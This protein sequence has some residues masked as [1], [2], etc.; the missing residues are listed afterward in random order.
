MYQRAAFLVA[1]SISI[2]L[3]ASTAALASL[4]DPLLELD[5]NEDGVVTTQELEARAAERWS[6]NDVDRDGKV[7]ANE[8]KAMLAVFRHERFAARDAD[9]SGLLERAELAD[10][11]E[12]VVLRFDIDKNGALSQAELDNGLL[13]LEH[14]PMQGPV[15][16][17]LGDTDD[18]GALILAEATAAARTLAGRADTNSDGKLSAEELQRAP[19]LRSYGPLLLGLEATYAG[20]P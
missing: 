6:T 5:A 17:L 16:L 7:T 9:C 10:M 20:V 14:D 11:P 15:K 2:Q 1:L 18:D 4:A 19:A 13:A 8:M 12:S 3:V